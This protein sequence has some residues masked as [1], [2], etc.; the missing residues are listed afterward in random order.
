MNTRYVKPLTILLLFSVIL[1]TT[2]YIR[3]KVKQPASASWKETLKSE[4]PILGHRNWILI[5]DKAYPSQSANGITTINTNE[6]L[7]SVLNFTLE[8]LKSCSHVKPV[9]FTD[10]ELNYITKN[11]VPDIESYRTNLYKSIG[12]LHPHVL[13]HDS[14]FVKIDKASK[15]FNV[16]ILKTNQV[17][18]YSSVFIQLNCKYWSDEKEMQLRKAMQNPMQ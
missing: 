3:E 5:V 16:I 9:V 14:V 13:L 1:L 15:L 7:L 8:Q 11:Q 12:N 4:L 2:L 17:I 18:P 10:K 6:D